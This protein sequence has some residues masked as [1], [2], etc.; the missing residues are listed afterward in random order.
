MWQLCVSFKLSRFASNVSNTIPQDQNEGRVSSN[1]IVPRFWDI[2][3]MLH[4]EVF[5]ESY[6]L[7]SVGLFN[8]QL[9]RF[10]YNPNSTT[11][12]VDLLLISVNEGPNF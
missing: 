5:V 8:M 2:I 3:G 9:S 11:N 4:F 10:S 6:R 7:L 12:F 1:I